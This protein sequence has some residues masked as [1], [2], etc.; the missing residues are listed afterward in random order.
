MLSKEYS[1]TA[2]ALLRIARTMSDES[3]VDRL[4]VLADDY[5]RRA[6]TASH[7]ESTKSLAAVVAGGESQGR[8]IK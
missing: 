2:R 5:E 6:A 7:S 3:I 4:K 1:D 8:T